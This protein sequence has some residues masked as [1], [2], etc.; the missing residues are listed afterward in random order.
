MS[1]LGD[2]AGAAVDVFNAGESLYQN[3][4]QKDVQ[5]QT[6]AREDNAVQRRV[7]D[8]KA[9]G[10][11]P[12]LAAGS[13]A[14]SSS[15]INVG[16]PQASSGNLM[17]SVE[18]ES[19]RKQQAVTDAQVDL[20]KSQTA[21]ADAQKE[22][23][24]ANSFIPSLLMD[25]LRA[26]ATNSGTKSYQFIQST[27]D[28][29]IADNKAAV[30]SSEESVRNTDIARS[31]GIRSDLPGIGEMLAQGSIVDSA[32]QKVFGGTKLS[33]A[34]QGVIGLLLKFLPGIIKGR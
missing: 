25:T 11:S 3:Q 34:D 15:P 20:V 5:Q 28:K 32:A 24:Q 18:M 26:D 29:Q 31:E 30:R 6:W 12:T 23:T 16:V 2:I 4:Y 17:R 14:S 9:A 7:A 13:A 19:A 8:L 33:P 22:A 21:A 1:I 27:I 10:L